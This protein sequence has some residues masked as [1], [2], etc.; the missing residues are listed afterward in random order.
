MEQQHNNSLVRATEVL[1]TVS[2]SSTPQQQ[3]QN[4]KRRG[5]IVIRRFGSDNDFK[6]KVSPDTQASFGANPEAAITGDY[7]TLADI[8]TAYGEGFA[9][10]WL[11]PHI[12]NLALYTG[13]KNLTVEQELE[14]SRIIASSYG[15][16]KITELLLFFFR[17]KAGRYGHFYGSVDP[18]VITCAMQD[19][20]AERNDILRNHER[21]QQENF[22]DTP[23]ISDEKLQEYIDRLSKKFNSK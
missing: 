8:N 3:L 2:W 17:F 9:A 22:E 11:M 23:A 13:A 19:F 7:P 15:Y 10:E 5:E 12:A 1:P 21:E 14:L 20:M 18:M 6:L 16:L 4:L